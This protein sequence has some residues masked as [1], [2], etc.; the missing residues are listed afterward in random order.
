MTTILKRVKTSGPILKDFKVSGSNTD[1]MV[2]TLKISDD[3]S[4]VLNEK[5]Q[6]HLAVM[7][8]LVG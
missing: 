2:V 8:R 1:E 6:L 7:G 5:N 3:E 4:G